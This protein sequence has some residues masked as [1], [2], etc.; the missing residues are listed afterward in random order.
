M[1]IIWL[2]RQRWIGKRSFKDAKRN[3]N[4]SSISVPNLPSSPSLLYHT[5]FI[6]IFSRQRSLK[7]PRRELL[8]VRTRTAM[9]WWHGKSLMVRKGTNIHHWHHQHQQLHHR[10]RNYEVK[11]W[12]EELRC[13]AMRC[14]LICLHSSKSKGVPMLLPGAGQRQRQ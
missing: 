3:S 6:G 14:D 9:E 2:T 11:L 13:D 4:P 10:V 1:G 8:P 7:W 5:P 12:Y